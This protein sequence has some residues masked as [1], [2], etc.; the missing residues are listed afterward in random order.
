VKDNKTALKV[1]NVVFRYN[2]LLLRF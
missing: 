2:L 1:V